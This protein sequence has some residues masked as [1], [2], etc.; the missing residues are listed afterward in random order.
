MVEEGD[1]GCCLRGR[2]GWKVNSSVNGLLACHLTG[3]Q[4]GSC[5]TIEFG[6]FVVVVL[7]K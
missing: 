4:Q 2:E 5:N 3:I 1:L 6:K 7:K